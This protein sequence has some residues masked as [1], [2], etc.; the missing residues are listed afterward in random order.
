MNVKGELIHLMFFLQ[1]YKG[2]ITFDLLVASLYHTSDT[3][4]S[5]RGLLLKE[6]IL[7]FNAQFCI[8]VTCITQ[9]YKSGPSCSKHR[10][11]NEL[12]RRATR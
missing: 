11:L 5:N 6:Q 12:V 4:L 7:S 8:T 3:T 9:I 1:F 10:Q 2:E